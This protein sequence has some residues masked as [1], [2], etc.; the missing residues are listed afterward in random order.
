MKIILLKSVKDLGQK[1]E[2]K[3]VK[4]GYGRNFLIARGLAKLATSSVISERESEVKNLQEHELKLKKDAEDLKR[5]IESA[6]LS[7]NVATNDQGIVFGSL[8][9]KDI[10][11]LLKEKGIVIDKSQ[12]DL[13]SPIKKL[14][15]TAIKVNLYKKEI[16]AN[17]KVAAQPS[18]NFKNN[19]P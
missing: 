19:R 2:I 4:E 6:V 17:L 5:K 3:K 16:I 12:I 9:V 14:G 8:N 1:G 18:L 15:E 10:V 11:K 7:A 13:K